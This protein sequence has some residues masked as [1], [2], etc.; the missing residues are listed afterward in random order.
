MKT[1][2]I[3]VIFFCALT[4]HVNAQDADQQ[5]FWVVETNV[6]ARR[7]SIV[8]FYN[9]QNALVHEIKIENKVIDINRPRHK[10]RVESLLKRYSNSISSTGKK[11]KVKTQI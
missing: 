3:T 1:T 8:K 5:L 10:R 9:A 2:I 7:S 6:N 4:P 11:S